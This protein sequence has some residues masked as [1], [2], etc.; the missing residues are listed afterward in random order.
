VL[1]LS[2]PTSPVG[3]TRVAGR[4]PRVPTFVEVDYRSEGTFLFTSLGAGLAAS[5]G[6]FVRTEDPLP[7]GTRLQLYFAGTGAPFEL[8]GEV[9]WTT[10]DAERTGMGVRFL[11]V[12]AKD[13]VRL[14]ELVGTIAYVDAA[15][16]N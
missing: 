5:L 16:A 11:A 2:G 10:R 9:V 14:L 13:R 1:L 7:Q 8:L 12:D 3:G 4:L 6:I 15:S